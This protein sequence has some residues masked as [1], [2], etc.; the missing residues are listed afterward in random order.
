MSVRQLSAR[1]PIRDITDQQV[2]IVSVVV[3]KWKQ[4]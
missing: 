2:R 4:Y 3:E 1:Y